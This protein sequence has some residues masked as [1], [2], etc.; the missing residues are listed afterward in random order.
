[1]LR[2]N[3]AKSV[4]ALRVKCG[5]S[6]G[7]LSKK[8]G[9]SIRYLSRLENEGGNLTLDVVEKLAHG[10]SCEPGEILGTSKS[11][12]SKRDAEMLDEAIRLLSSVRSRV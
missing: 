2:K 3:I 7:E 4:K 10:L 12:V 11:S 6:Q 9:L 8:S 5:L 1:M